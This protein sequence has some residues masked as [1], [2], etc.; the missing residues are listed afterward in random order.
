V[1]LFA[2]SAIVILMVATSLVGV[3]AG[4]RPSRSKGAAGERLAARYLKDLNPTIYQVFHD[5]YLPRPDGRGTT[6][7]DHV[8][9]SRFGV[10]VVETKDYDG[11]IFGGAR[12]KMWTQSLFG[13]NTQFQNPL[14]QNHLHVLALRAFLGLSE[15]QFHSLVF[16]VEG[17]FR[18]EMPENVICSDLCGWIIG[19]R[20][21]LLSDEPLF[22]SVRRLEELEKNTNRK[23]A[24]VLHYEG[25]QAIRHEA[26]DSRVVQLHISDSGQV[27]QPPPPVDSP[28]VTSMESSK[29]HRGLAPV[30]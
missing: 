28:W 20:A 14:H 1:I 19:R 2:A 10:F 3:L 11:W 5:L 17:D 13:R 29:E 9:L 27:V 23:S 16:F 25:L 12:Q 8:I 6:Q 21:T 7:I 15:R 30:G 22:E 18:S 24:K 26:A 4:L